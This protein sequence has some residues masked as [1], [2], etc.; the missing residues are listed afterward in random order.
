ML[1]GWGVGAGTCGYFGAGVIEQ[2]RHEDNKLRWIGWD[3]IPIRRCHN[4]LAFSRGSGDFNRTAPQRGDENSFFWAF[5]PFFPVFDVFLRQPTIFVHSQTVFI[6]VQIAF[7][8]SQKQFV[9]VQIA[10]VHKQKPFVRLQ[11]VFVRKE[12]PFVHV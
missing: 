12:K 1:L 4:N 11:T 2:P 8:H 6:H 9:H 10:F 5:L 3:I 7:V